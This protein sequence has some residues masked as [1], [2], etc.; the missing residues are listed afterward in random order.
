[1][2]RP[3]H[4]SVNVDELV[5]RV[6]V[7]DVLRFYGVPCDAI[8]QIG[9]EIRTRCF[10]NCSKTEPT[11]DRTLAIRADSDAK[12]WCCHQ[13]ECEHKQGGNLV[14]LIDMM[15]PGPHMNGRPRGDRFR[16]ILGDLEKIAGGTT[17]PPP[18]SSPAAK[19][20][21]PEPAKV[22]TPLAESENERA[23]TVVNLHDKFVV[24]PL[25][26]HPAAA[27][28]FRR[29]P[30]LTPEQCAKWKMGYLPGD[31][32]G[33]KTGGT[34]RGKIVY[35]I[36]DEHG[37]ILTFFGRDPQ[38]SEKHA[39]WKASDRSQS[40]P[41]RFHFVKG[42]HRGLE[43][44]GQHRISEPQVREAI[45]TLGYLLLV[46]GANNSLR[47]DALG[48]PAFA[49]CSNRITREQAKK[50]AGWCRELGVA[51]AVMFDCDPEGEAG[52]QQAVIELAQH[53]AVRL[54]WSRS[55]FDGR[56]IDRQPESLRDDE[57]QDIHNA[58]N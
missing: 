35:P 53:C 26:M 13:Y 42:Y 37:R 20:A 34:M 44:F 5:R 14:G 1:M 28:Y 15:K 50:A 39:A 17:P 38:H 56:F 41:E 2:N 49:V 25:A 11:G 21:Q 33:S 40:E 12:K 36:H 30:Y 6:S 52:A 4:N 45:Q 23:R 29:R 32:G 24:D 31:T 22:N 8:H 51:V 7:E 27:S 57:W 19:V 9:G 16:A 55:M 54:A 58:F 3:S 18:A 43:I 10:L 47:L 48:V 46:E